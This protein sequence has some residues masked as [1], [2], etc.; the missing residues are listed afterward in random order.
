[1]KTHILIV[2]DEILQLN[3]IGKIIRRYRPEYELQLISRWR[4][5]NC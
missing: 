3:C 2:D 5:W 4:L 1:M